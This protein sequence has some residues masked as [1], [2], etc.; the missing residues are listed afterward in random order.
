LAYTKSYTAWAD[1]PNVTTPATAAKLQNL[2]DG[3]ANL[4]ATVTTLNTT[5]VAVS[6]QAYGSVLKSVGSASGDIIYFSG[7][8]TPARLGIGSS[9]QI[10]AVSGGLPKWT[11]PTLTTALA[12]TTKALTADVTM[13]NAN[14]FYDGP[15]FSLTAGSYLLNSVVTLTRAGGAADFTAKLWDGTTVRASAEGSTA[16][17]GD[18]VVIP[19]VAA[20]ALTATATMKVSVASTLAT[21]VMKAA[22][23]DNGAGNNASNLVAVQIA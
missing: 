3:V 7:V 23:T 18:F 21:N 11:S 22:A 4:D 1:Y 9:N 17:A 10:L 16:A 13:T 12:N 20:F 19:L 5:V 15:S 8:S 6:A 14:Q 2:D